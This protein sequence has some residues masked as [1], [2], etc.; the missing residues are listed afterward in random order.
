M[1]Y[2]ELLLQLLTDENRKLDTD[3]AMVDLSVQ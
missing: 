1:A 3:H 2:T